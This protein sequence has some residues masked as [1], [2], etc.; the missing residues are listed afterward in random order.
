MRFDLAKA[1]PHPV[2]RPSEY[3]DDYPAA[4]FR[5]DVQVSQN[6]TRTSVEVTVEFNLDDPDLLGLVEDG[7]ARYVLLIKASR[8]NFR[9]LIETAFPQVRRVFSGGN[10]SGRVEFAPFLISKQR[11]P[12][13][14]VPG[15]HNDFDGMTFDVDAGSVLAED[16]P[17][18]YWIDAAD[19]SLLGTIIGHKEGEGLED[20]RWEYQLEEDRIWILM[21]RRDAERYLIAR[22]GADSQPEGQYLINGLYLPVL[23]AV[24]DEVDRDPDEYRDFRWFASLDHRLEELGCYPLGVGN[25]NRAV[26]SQKVL[27]SPFPK[28]PMIA[29]VEAS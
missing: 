15:W 23:I 12:E 6:K 27:E 21:S 19:E 14:R 9:D 25:A 5:A 20:G 8:T 24:L 16:A 17:S 4:E 29:A 22:D 2:L 10:L 11:I 7:T 28:M 13:F 1:W 3:G 26:D 18:D